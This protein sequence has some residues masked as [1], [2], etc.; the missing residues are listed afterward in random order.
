MSLRTSTPFCPYALV[1]CAVAIPATELQTSITEPQCLLSGSNRLPQDPGSPRVSR[2]DGS[3][4]R[5]LCA[6]LA[7][8][9]PSARPA[10]RHWPR[11]ASRVQ[12]RESG[13]RVTGT[14][15]DTPC[16]GGSGTAP[17][18]PSR[19]VPENF[20]VWITVPSALRGC[21]DRPE[22]A[23]RGTGGSGA[24]WEGNATPAGVSRVPPQ[25]HTTSL[26]RD[27]A[28]CP[29]HPASLR[30]RDPAP[31]DWRLALPPLTSSLPS[32]ATQEGT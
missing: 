19:G 18:H 28:S 2:S 1:P 24:E 12:P 10:V 27:T 3:G 13:P 8:L 15:R 22:A 16:R 9:G 5:L 31:P 14:R 7:V 20:R 23:R 17:G 6:A 30:G 21:R 32:A 29:G 25:G 11:S 26:S 4:V